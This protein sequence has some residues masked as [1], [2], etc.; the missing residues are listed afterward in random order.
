MATITRHKISLETWRA[1]LEKGI[2]SEND[3]V[4]L[5]EGEIF[6]MSPIGKLHIA[7]VIRI[8]QLLTMLLAKKAFVSVQNPLHL[9]PDSEP[10]P[11]IALLKPR[12][13]YYASQLPEAADTFLVIE[14]ADSSLEYDREVKK[15]LY[16]KAG[17]PCFWLVNL[18]KF[19]IEVH[20]QP[21]RGTYKQIQLLHPGDEVR[22]PVP[23][24]HEKIFVSDLLGPKPA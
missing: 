9:P 12:E 22:L 17:V 18:Q 4:E 16:A 15:P 14:V 5:I 3:R 10:E 11:D 6:D 24:F 19:E 8:N 21:G 7:T 23:G 20:T 1:M 13:D 2:L